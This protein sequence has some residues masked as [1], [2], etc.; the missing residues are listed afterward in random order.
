MTLR[1]K[2]ISGVIWTG[3]A[4]LVL[5]VYMIVVMIIL[6]RL[7]AVRDF[8]V[9]GMAPLL[10]VAMSIVNDR[11]L[12]TAII[13]KRNLDMAH[14]SSVF[15]GGVALGVVLFFISLLAADPLA[16]FL[17]EP[18]LGPVISVLAA[19]FIIGAF[20]IVQRGLLTR[21]MS[22]KQL[23]FI[24]VV[25]V[26]VSGTL[27]I[28]MALLGFGVWSLVSNILF[29]YVLD[30]IIFW[31]VSQWRPRFHFRFSEF[32]EYLA[33]S[34][35]VMMTDTVVYLNNVADISIIEK[36]LGST[37]FGYYSMAMNFVKIPVTRLSAIVSKV[38]FP[39][40]SQ[41]QNDLL[42]FKRAYLKATTLISLITF[43]LLTGMALLAHEFIVVFF[44]EKWLPMS[45]PLIILAP[46]A[47]L[48]SVGTIRGPVFKACGRP[49]ILLKWNVAYF[50][51]LVPSIY[52]GTRYGLTGVAACFTGLYLVTFP[53]IQIITNRQLNIRA[54]E[55]IRAIATSSLGSLAMLGGG[56]F[57]KYML[58]YFFKFH[59]MVVLFSCLI[60][61]A[62]LYLMTVRLL[63]REVIDELI[64][65]FRQRKIVK[66]RQEKTNT[67]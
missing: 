54:R 27:A 17:H 47:L 33:F 44:T 64:R 66:N 46:M 67:I 8:G 20:A 43:P 63:D 42:K 13:Q 56:A 26:A 23:A 39:A 24:E 48:K 28:V 15:W 32:K 62:L 29:K 10:T 31:A 6:A 3:I 58:K 1:Q 19:G 14:L 35:S 51:L 37:L 11:G 34:G 30:V 2:T 65:L 57:L 49:D 4:K 21:E 18:R 22:F 9:I 50:V 5:Q 40:F 16:G 53:L 52:W 36:M 25:S 12:G 41:V 60:F 45:M 55:Y 38:V 61:C 7:L 59:E